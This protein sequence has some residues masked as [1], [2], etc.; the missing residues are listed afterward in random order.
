MSIATQLLVSCLSLLVGVVIFC[1]TQLILRSLIDP[2]QKQRDIRG[3]V[4]S[5]L[6]F[7]AWAISNPREWNN[8]PGNVEVEKGRDSLRGLAS[9]LYGNILSVPYRCLEKDAWVRRRFYNWLKRKDWIRPRN[10]LAEAARILIG[11][12]NSLFCSRDTL[13]EQRKQNKDDLSKVRR[14]L[15]LSHPL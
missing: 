3:K 7:W 13:E 10:D 6:V 11:I 9:E 8:S 1:V 14:L 12:S 2:I 15:E 4:Q 5:E